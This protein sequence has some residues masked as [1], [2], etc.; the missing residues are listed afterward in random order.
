MVWFGGRR[1]ETQVMLC[2]G[3]RPHLVAL[4]PDLGTI[5]QVQQAISDW[6]AAMELELKPSKTRITHT[7]N[8]YQG[9]LG[10]DFLGFNVRQ[11]R[12]GKTHSGKTSGP[13]PQRLGFKTII[14]PSQQAQRPD[15]TTQSYH[16]RLE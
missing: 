3:R 13:K 7:L 2:A 4:H 12:T 10:F 15:Q 9:K 8:N 11:Y 14:K 16:P 5:H 6:L 1:L